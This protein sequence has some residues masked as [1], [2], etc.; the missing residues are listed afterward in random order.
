MT[1]LPVA[2]SRVLWPANDSIDIFATR[3]VGESFE[4]RN[5]ITVV[6]KYPPGTVAREGCRGGGRAGGGGVRR[7]SEG[8]ARGGNN[9]RERNNDGEQ[10]RW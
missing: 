6:T 7:V 8:G 9:G 1:S 2:V 4:G 3:P 10:R 5:I